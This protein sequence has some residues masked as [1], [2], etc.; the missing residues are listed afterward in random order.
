MNRK[1]TIIVSARCRLFYRG[2]DTPGPLYLRLFEIFS[3]KEQFE[4]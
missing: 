4:E 1:K 2:A 3:G